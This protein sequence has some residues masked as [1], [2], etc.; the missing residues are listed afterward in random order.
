MEP[1]PS[2]LRMLPKRPSGADHIQLRAT[3]PYGF[4]PE[5]ESTIVFRMCTH[6]R[7]F[8]ALSSSLNHKLFSSR[9][10][11]LLIDAAQTCAET[12]QK[13]PQN[14]ELV[15]ETV[16]A[17]VRKGKASEDELI[18]CRDYLERAEER[19]LPAWTDTR[20]LLVQTLMRYL[21]LEVVTESREAFGKHK[22]L[23][24]I[25][26]IIKKAQKLEYNSGNI[27][28]FCNEEAAALIRQLVTAERL[29]TGIKELDVRLKGGFMR[30]ST[31]AFVGG[32][33]AGKSMMLTQMAFYITCILKE[34]VTLATFELAEAWQHA[35]YMACATG[36]PTN[37]LIQQPEAA[38]ALLNQMYPDR[39]RFKCKYFAPK[40]ATMEG[41]LDWRDEFIEEEQ[42][43][44]IGNLLDY[45]N[46]IR[47]RDGK[48]AEHEIFNRTSDTLLNYNKE[49]MCWG[50]T[51]CAPKADNDAPVA[52]DANGKFPFPGAGK[53]GGAYAIA[54]NFD[55]IIQLVRVL[56]DG[57]GTKYTIYPVQ[58]KDRLGCSEQEMFVGD[59][60]VQDFTRARICTN[61][62]QPIMELPTVEVPLNW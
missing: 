59:E 30:G 35:R 6:R 45:F 42:L 46:K 8:D 61:S 60:M 58:T 5:F 54:K 33:G 15:L 39:G 24:P 23:E 52:R 38:L 14:Y 32:T 44:Y 7:F 53:I 37:E 4:D 9:I 51:A 10:P 34:N 22:G 48:G 26:H 11:Q 36:V 40:E 25:K 17:F 55:N 2:N 19:T 20:K 43:P 12:L 31:I 49:R 18:P 1:T 62:L 3:D 29:G 28:T 13:S 21:E 41:V 50:A 27:G 16:A 47:A 57:D 56:R